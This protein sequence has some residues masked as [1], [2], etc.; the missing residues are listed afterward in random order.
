[1]LRTGHGTYSVARI[2]LVDSSVADGDAM[3]AGLVASMRAGAEVIRAET[4]RRAS[5]LLR[6][7]PFDVVL[8]DLAALVDL[9]AEADEAVARVVKLAAGALVIALSDGAS[10]SAT[11]AAMRAGAHDYL[12]RPVSG[13]AV[14]IRINE[15]A[16][17]HGKSQTLSI[18]TPLPGAD[19]HFAGIV[20]TSSQMQVVFE[21]LERVAGAAAPV[22]ITGE[23]GTGKD[24]CADALHE[25]STRAKNRLVTLRCR[26]VPRDQLE[27]ELFGVSR[28][29]TTGA[30][31]D[32]KGAAELADG[33]TL[34]LDEIGELDLSVQGKLLRFLQT[35]TL[36]R[37]G[38][39]ALRR[40]DVRVICATRHNPMHLISEKRFREDLF[41][42]LHVLPVHLPPLRQRAG[43]VAVLARHFLD[44]FA[45]AE[46]KTFSGLTAEAVALLNARDWPGN[47]RQ[48]RELMQR[49]VVMHTGGD[50]TAAMV[51]LADLDRD[52]A[53]QKS[54]AKPS[55][56]PM[57]QQEQR[58]IEEAIASFAGNVALAAA[59]LELSPS[60]IYRKR[61]SWA[62]MDERRG[63]A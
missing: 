12:V 48:L 1:M 33:G 50:I 58:I 49:V 3:E 17:R 32:R 61:Q 35:G 63:A 53:T 45:A 9:C 52:V 23:S 29:A 43:D 16:Q 54:P 56:L 36:T 60:T 4:G 2:L 8:V 30:R 25:L 14:A 39:S 57:W 18:D 22:F 5:E 15:L 20:G 40:A 46:H 41:Y 7:E 59:A 21:Q 42:R 34:V 19:G 11:M 26:A 47:V 31:E 24:L 6:A 44:E 51:Q 37:V 27:A 28:G 62:E 38:E 10:V 55:V 13:R